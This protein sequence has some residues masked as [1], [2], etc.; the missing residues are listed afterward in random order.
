M[1]R[2]ARNMVVL[3]HTY[4]LIDMPIIIAGKTGTAEFADGKKTKNLPFNQWFAGFVPKDPWD[5]ASDPKGWKAVQRTDSNLAVLVFAY[6]SGTGGNTATEI[7]KYYLQMH[8]NL[9]KDYRIMYVLRRSRYLSPR[10]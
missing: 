7:A 5:H 6:D 9:K 4:N 10:D 1:R 8:F 3:R 2:A